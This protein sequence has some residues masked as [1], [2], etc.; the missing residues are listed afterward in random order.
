MQSTIQQAK[1]EII[2][3]VDPWLHFFKLWTKTGHSILYWRNGACILVKKMNVY[4]LIRTW[5]DTIM[6][7]TEVIGAL[8]HWMRKTRST[9]ELVL[10]YLSQSH[11]GWKYSGSYD[12]LI[13]KCM[14][15]FLDKKG[16]IHFLF[17]QFSLSAL[18]IFKL[19]LRTNWPHCTLIG[20]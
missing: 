5:R 3:T 6:K 13:Q 20:H 4:L 19:V 1:N 11:V 10:V 2:Q 12:Y 7:T 17:K 14:F 18:K 16:S 15:H 9:R 8:L